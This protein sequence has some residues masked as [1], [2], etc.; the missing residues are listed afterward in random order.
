[1]EC[2]HDNSSLCQCRVC[3]PNER[4]CGCKK[5]L[6]YD[7][8]CNN[9]CN[10]FQPDVRDCHLCRAEWKLK[11]IGKTVAYMK[12]YQ[13]SD[14]KIKSIQEELLKELFEEFDE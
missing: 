10:T 11:R 6:E 13:W 2:L 4:P 3:T 14:R 7:N 9:N 5:C 1:M 12:R 8:F